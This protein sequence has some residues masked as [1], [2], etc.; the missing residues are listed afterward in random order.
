MK[1]KY[2]FP[3]LLCLSCSVLNAQ[4]SISE[5]LSLVEA[6]N[7]QLL[8]LQSEMHATHLEE[9]NAYALPDMDFEMEQSWG[10]Q[11]ESGQRTELR[12][13]QEFDATTLL[14]GARRAIRS[15]QKALE[16]EYRQ[17]RMEVLCNTKALCMDII[18][19][20]QLLQLR[21]ERAEN[22]RQL[23]SAL[24]KKLT[25]GSADLLQVNRAKLRYAQA[26]ADSS[27]TVVDLQRAKGTLLQLSSGK[28]NDIIERDFAPILL[29]K[30]FESWFASE[31]GAFPTL[32]ALDAQVEEKKQLLSAERLALLPSFSVGYLFEKSPGEKMNGFTIGLSIPFWRSGGKV[33][34]A[35]A[36]LQNAELSHAKGKESLRITLRNL[37]YEASS[38][39]LHAA[40]LQRALSEAGDKRLPDKA[41]V[42]GKL[43][44][45]N[46]LNE[47]AER[48]ELEDKALEATYKAS[49]LYVALT[50]HRL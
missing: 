44:L 26:I 5:A 15:N 29:P 11:K 42:L 3:L 40:T 8:L 37:F 39:A 46:Y 1:I 36:K 48:Y 47:I 31:E 43:S 38:E 17:I 19:Y 33:R 30:D 9:A 18:Y 45:E 25:L 21:S 14:G 13:A 27:S 23:V 7:P 22:A 50:G 16:A 41:F 24:E 4:V 20:R 6:H 2:I 28:V 32:Q 49:R 35:K 12:I 10:T 34:A